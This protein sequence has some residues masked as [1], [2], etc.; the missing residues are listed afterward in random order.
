MIRT[1]INNNLLNKDDESQ[2]ESHVFLNIQNPD[3]EYDDSL[4]I[5]TRKMKIMNI[6]N[7]PSINSDR[8]KLDVNEFEE[9]QFLIESEGD[10]S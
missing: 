2:A 8:K 3:R 7:K 1:E 10:D 5:E 6:Q 9:I 4:D